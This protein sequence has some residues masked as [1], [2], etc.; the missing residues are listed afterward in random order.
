MQNP[1]SM[2]TAIHPDFIAGIDSAVKDIFSNMYSEQ[3]R[4]VPVEEISGEIGLSSIIGFAGKLSGFLALHFDRKTAC[5][6]ASGLLGMDIDD[7]DETVRDAAGELVNM[8]A[9]GLKNNL[10]QDEEIFKISMPS[11]IEG[12]EYSTYPPADAQNILVGVNA[13]KYQFRVQLVV[14]KS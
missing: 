12:K 4:V 9:G 11:V 5:L 7:V 8:L 1:V 2:S 10:S 3:A 13:G 6:L 14:E